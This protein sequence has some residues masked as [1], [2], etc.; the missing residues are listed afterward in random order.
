MAP[1]TTCAGCP[2][3]ILPAPAPRLSEV[4]LS[5]RPEPAGAFYVVDEYHPGCWAAE[6]RRPA[7]A[8]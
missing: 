7:A 2:S 5:T 8:S 3:P 1:D 6:L 4:V